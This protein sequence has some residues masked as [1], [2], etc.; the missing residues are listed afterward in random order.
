[1]GMIT[2]LTE[3]LRQLDNACRAL[4]TMYRKDPMLAADVVV[5]SI[6]INNS[7]DVRDALG[8]QKCCF[9]FKGRLGQ[10]VS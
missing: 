8:N 5:I 3:S 4:S 7:S 9:V 2:H 10:L 6:I 1:M